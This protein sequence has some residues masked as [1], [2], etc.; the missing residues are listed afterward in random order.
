MNAVCDQERQS[1]LDEAQLQV[2][3]AAAILEL[4]A[5]YPKQHLLDRFL[6]PDKVILFR[7]TLQRDDGSN[8][9]YEGYRVQHSDV[10]GCY[11]GGIRFHLRVDLNEV[12]A[13][14]LWMALK[15]ALVAIPYGG[16]K[17][18]IAVDPGTL[19][20]AERERLTRKYTSYLLNDIGPHRDIPAPDVGTG[21]QEMAWIYDEYRK[22]NPDALGAV[23]G[24]PVSL[25]GS[26]GRAAATGNGV[27]FVMREALR[28]LG[29][30][31]P[32]VAIQGFG[33]VGMNAALACH[34]LGLPVVGV[35]DISGSLY[36][37]DGLDI[38][39]LAA[40]V[41]AT[42]TLAGFAEAES[43]PDVLT[44]PC[45]ILLPCALEG[46][47]TEGNAGDI[48]ARLI[49]EGA[50]GPTTAA[51][52]ALLQGRGVTVVP[53]ILANAGGV[54]VSYYEWVQNREGFYWDEATVRERL[55]ITITGAYAKVVA[56]AREQDLSLRQAAYCLGLERIAAG[57]ALS[58]VQ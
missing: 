6:M 12:K 57:M 56:R 49:V 23:T 26:L 20:V 48:E 43:I 3:Q 1:V 24:K 45:E 44:C 5:L 11:K 4:E 29:L 19:S 18:G 42:R 51:A 33:N 32:R 28:E 50:N 35:S 36:R 21:E 39:A 53:D 2:R 9:L 41:R 40:H 46:A 47:I 52:D 27:V 37:A 7:V 25:G 58:G 15:T 22:H 14:A 38:P 13:L 55:D 54:I 8:V 10:L 17:G 30:E 34:G 16:A 31:K